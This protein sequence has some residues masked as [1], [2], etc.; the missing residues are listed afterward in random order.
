[1]ISDRYLRE[2]AARDPGDGAFTE[3]EQAALAMALPVIAAELLRHRGA[4]PTPDDRDRADIIDLR[5]H[6]A[7]NVIRLPDARPPEIEEACGIILTHCHDPLEVKCAEEVLRSM[8]RPAPAPT[9]GDA[10]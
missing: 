7:R 10:A 9:G 8:R 3:T 4:A 5:L 1:M 6:M 2:L